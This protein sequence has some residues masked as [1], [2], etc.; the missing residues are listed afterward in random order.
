V[1]V[2]FGPPQASGTIPL[3]QQVAYVMGGVGS[4]PPNNI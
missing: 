4:Y 3:Q 1:T 2:T